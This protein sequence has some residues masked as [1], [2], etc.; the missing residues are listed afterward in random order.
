MS[1]FKQL[2]LSMIVLQ[3]DG[4]WFRPVNFSVIEAKCVYGKCSKILKTSCLPKWPRQTVQ[5]SDGF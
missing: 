3:I 2:S 5:T 4:L 1:N